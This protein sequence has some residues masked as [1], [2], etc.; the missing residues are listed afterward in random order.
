MTDTVYFNTKCAP[1]GQ[2][3]LHCEV[4]NT[5]DGVVQVI[6]YGYNHTQHKMQFPLANVQ[7]IEY[8]RSWR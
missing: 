7:R 5:R 1:G 8:G 4:Q 6:V 2:D 3:W